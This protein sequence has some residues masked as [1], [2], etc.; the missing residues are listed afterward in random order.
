MLFDARGH[1]QSDGD[2][3]ITILKFAED[4]QSA[5]DYLVARR[6]FD[7]GRI[8]VLGHSIGAS[9]AIIAAISDN[10]IRT[11]VSS[12]AFADPAQLTWR[13][14]AKLHLPR[15]PFLAIARWF[16]ERWLRTGMADVSP[17]RDV[18]K[19]TGPLLLIHGEA[20]R[21]VPPSDLGILHGRATTRHL[22][23]WLVP[24]RE[25]S[26]VLYHRDFAPRVVDFFADAPA[27]EPKPI[28]EEPLTPP[29]TAADHPQGPRSIQP[30]AA[31][32]RTR[33]LT[34]LL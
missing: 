18:D 5:V 21:F 15:F 8:G 2:G 26:S 7:P 25:H 27:G 14:M 28:G 20:D 13:V 30:P 32:H 33:S 10:R 34:G 22:Q 11:L 31:I 1:G 3:P 23:A 17:M 9:A 16:I 4:I 6:E 19:I 24:R 12:S 29:K